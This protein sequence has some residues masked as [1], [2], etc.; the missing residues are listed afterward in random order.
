MELVSLLI[1]LSGPWTSCVPLHDCF[2]W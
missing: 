1:M 2:T